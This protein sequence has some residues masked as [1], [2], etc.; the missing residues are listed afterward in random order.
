MLLSRGGTEMHIYINMSKHD[1][2]VVENVNMLFNSE[3]ILAVG[4]GTDCG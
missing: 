2:A 3:S 1:T 4:T